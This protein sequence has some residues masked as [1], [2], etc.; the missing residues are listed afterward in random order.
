MTR[1]VSSLHRRGPA[2]HMRPSQTSRRRRPRSAPVCGC[3]PGRRHAA[4]TRTAASP[5]TT[6]GT[7]TSSSSALWPSS[8]GSSY[9]QPHVSSRP[10]MLTNA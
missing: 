1:G 4:H 10:S 5:G 6:I 2:D 3:L 7:G 8:T 9:S